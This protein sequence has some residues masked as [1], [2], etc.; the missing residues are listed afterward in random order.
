MESADRQPKGGLKAR[1]QGLAGQKDRGLAPVALA[2]QPDAVELEERPPVGGARWSLYL[3]ALLLVTAVLWAS[4][5]QVDRVVVARGKVVTSAPT[6]VVQPME[7]AVIHELVARVGQVV[8]QGAVLATLDP[9]FTQADVAQQRSRFK[10]YAAQVRRLQAEMDN[11]PF[12]PQ[13]PND[14]DERLQADI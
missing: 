12:T 6:I 3:L 4:L 9:T 5:S 7:T 14:E 10:S 13:P 11:Q 1:L 2:Y 8:P